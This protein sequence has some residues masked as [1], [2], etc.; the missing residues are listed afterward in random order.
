[1]PFLGLSGRISRS[2]ATMK[3]AILFLG[4]ALV[5]T[6]PSSAGEVRAPSKDAP[7]EVP[8][9]VRAFRDLEYVPGGGRARSLDLYLPEKSDR[10]LPLVI[11]VHGG[12]FLGGDKSP[13]PAVRLVPLG[14]AA[15]SVN[16]RLSGEA[17]FPAQI[18]DCKAAV[19]WLRA[20]ASER[21]L[22][23]ERFGAWG[24]SAGGHLVAMLGT[25]GDVK[26]LEG[27]G[28]NPKVSSRV[29]AVCDFFG[30]TDFLQ[31][32]AHRVSADAQVHDAPDS[33][34]S[35][36]VGGAIQDN[37]EKVRR[38][39]PITYVTADDPPFL[40][41][42]G[43]RDPLV[44]HHQSVLLAEALRKAGVEVT[45]ETVRGAGHGFG[46]PEIDRKVD[47]FFEKHLKGKGR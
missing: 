3:T 40:I 44:P 37:P 1:L 31:M 35:K 6:L 14:Y 25:A 10:P 2:E 23:P 26:D 24:S 20:H 15:A 5:A 7:P 4:I 27:D 9:G 19:R 39:N 36:L 28:G 30:P 17:R 38:A 21:G 43:D 32:D 47:A 45:F 13:C 8:A 11:W 29:R 46:G 18:E 16:Y 33:P 42:H 41:L 34:E 12:A 22:D